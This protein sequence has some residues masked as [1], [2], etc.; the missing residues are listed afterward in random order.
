MTI[1]MTN[2][3]KRA[4]NFVFFYHN[5]QQRYEYLPVYRPLRPEDL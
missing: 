1:E 2:A 5:R 4:T 3:M